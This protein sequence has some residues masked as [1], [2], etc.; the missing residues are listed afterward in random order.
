MA[1]Q[2]P[3]PNANKHKQ[4]I[5][6]LRDF[7]GTPILQIGLY[8]YTVKVPNGPAVTRRIGENM[9]L[10][11]GLM[12]NPSMM[13]AAKPILV[14]ICQQCRRPKSSLFFQKKATHG[15]VSLEQAKHCVDCGTCCCPSHRQLGSDN[16]WRC[17][18]CSSKFKRKSIVKSIFFETESE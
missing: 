16:K 4:I 14:G 9:R 7:D 5:T 6:V 3:S 17:L 11:C 1:S 18:D 8:E 15:V 2:I 13:L 10:V 12:W